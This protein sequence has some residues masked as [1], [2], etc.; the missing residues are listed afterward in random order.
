MSPRD[1]V[2][3][4]VLAGGTGRRFGGP[5]QFTEVAGQR[6]VDLALARVAEVCAHVVLTLPVEVAS[7]ADGG[8]SPW[9]GA[10]VDRIVPAGADRV[11]SVRAALEAV[12]DSAEIIVVHQAAN[13]L[14][15]ADLIRRV[16]ARVRAGAGAAVPALAVP[17]VVGRVLDGYLV[18]HV[19]RDEFA[20]VQT[21]G[22]YRAQALRDAHA[23]GVAAIE[24]TG[25]VMADGGRVAVVPGEPTNVHVTTP[26]DIRHV[27]RLLVSD[28]GSS[29]R[30]ADHQTS[31]ARS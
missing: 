11:A 24:D 7:A 20:L 13:P 4:I 29:G 12:P 15:S 18:E 8:T 22:A 3:G 23:R 6:L 9:D 30:A 28:V 17:D 21:P 19:G 25:L 16:V 1:E 10:P 14:A 31:D 26:A 5:K 27:A 2:W